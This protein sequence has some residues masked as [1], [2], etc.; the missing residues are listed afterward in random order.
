MILAHILSM[1]VAVSITLYVL[2]LGQRQ[3]ANEGLLE[4]SASSEAQSTQNQAD[5]TGGKDRD[6]LDVQLLI[7]PDEN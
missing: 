5:L 7:P 4:S 6:G 2:S 3:A 1:V